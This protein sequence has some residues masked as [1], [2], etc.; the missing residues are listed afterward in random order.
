MDEIRL[1]GL[2]YSRWKRR[3]SQALSAFGI[4]FGQY[5]LIHLARQRGA[6]APSAAAEELGADRPTM[7]LVAR[8]CVA[9]GWLGRR[10]FGADRR[11]CRLSLTGEGEE[12]LDRIEAA[13]ALAPESMG[14]PFDILGTDERSELRRM[15]DKAERRARDLL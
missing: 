6:I 13:R 11:S 4:T 14:D 7:T 8:K 3:A 1:M 12:L 5:Q 2:T 10:R 15:L 9:S